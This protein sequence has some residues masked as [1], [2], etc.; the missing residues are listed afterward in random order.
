MVQWTTCGTFGVP[1]V[2]THTL[3]HSSAFDDPIP[4]LQIFAYRY[5]DDTLA[6]SWS[7]VRSQT[8]EGALH[9]MWQT[10]ASLG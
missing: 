3:T 9:A 1:S 4:L 2:K 7:L 10:F 6:P 5:R 8:V